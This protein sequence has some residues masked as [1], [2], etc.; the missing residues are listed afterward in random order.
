MSARTVGRT[1]FPAAVSAA[2]RLRE[3][4][5]LADGGELDLLVI[6]GGIT[7]VGIA[8]DAASRGLRTV[9]VERHDLAHG[10]SRFSSKLVH[11]GLRYL[12]SGQ[13]GIARESAVERHILLTRTAP[14]LTRALAQVVPLHEPGHVARGAYVGL[15]YELGNG[16]R[17]TVGT[18]GA[19]LPGPGAI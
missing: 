15:G 17:R 16:L 9:L 8:L 10:T 11:G 18:P 5:A 1:P 13:V 4:E 7:G 3:L 14:H 2:R 19:L 6:G 12:A